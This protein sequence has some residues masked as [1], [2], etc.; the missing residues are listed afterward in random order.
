MTTLRLAPGPRG[1]LLSGNLTEMRRDLLGLYTRCARDYGDVFSLRFGLRRVTFLCHPDLIEEV[2]VTHARNFTKHYA[3]RMNRTL[4]GNGLLTSEGDFWLRQRR[5]IQPAFLRDRVAAY[6]PVMVQ[7]AD[8]AADRWRDGEERDLLEDMT[9]LTLEIIARTLFGADVSGKAHEVG[10][11]LTGAMGTFGSRF[12][13]V[14][15]IPEEVP[16]PTNLRIR[17]AVARLDK[18][19]YDMIEQRRAGGGDPGDLLSILLHA[20]DEDDGGHMTDKQLRDEAMTLFLAGHDTTALTLS[21]T[22]FLLAQHPTETDRLQVELRDVLGGRPPTVDD[23]PR[24]P[25][26]EAVIQEAMRLYPPAYAIGRQAIAA[27]EIGGFQVPA[28][29]TIVMSQWIMHRQARWFNEPERFRPERWLDGLARKLPKYAYFPFGGGP[30]IC[31][32]NTFAMLEAVLVLATLAR[33]FR[34]TLAPGTVV[35]PRPQF[36]LRPE[37]G[38]PVLLH[39]S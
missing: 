31:I 3:L 39:K 15:R 17:R 13:R 22:W 30:R 29:G 9:R 19:V 33:R 7:Y 1:R 12:F 2:L 25:Y 16:T 28:G 20:R 35:R 32:G 21:W 24:L 8:R 37:P 5:M 18:I 27:C 36:T 23:L 11:A 6:A 14:I 34:C 26:T 10:E 38:V 4:L